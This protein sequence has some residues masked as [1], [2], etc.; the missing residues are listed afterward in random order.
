MCIRDRKDS[1]TP[2]STS[3]SDSGSA[4]SARNTT[5]PVTP[6][7]PTGTK[8][9]TTKAA[10]IR[11]ITTPTTSTDNGPRSAAPIRN[12]TTPTAANSGSRPDY[13][14]KPVSPRQTR[15]SQSLNLSAPVAVTIESVLPHQKP[16]L[17][18]PVDAP[19]CLFRAQQTRICSLEQFFVIKL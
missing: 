9:T 1:Q 10:P 18:S 17:P 3:R 5:A 8:A 14:A 11:H 7:G 6:A 15:S 16:I 19:G 2:R 13:P 12:A 4:N